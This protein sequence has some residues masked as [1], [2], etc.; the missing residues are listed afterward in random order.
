MV[1]ARHGGIEVGRLIQT[2]V[3]EAFGRGQAP[4]FGQEGAAG[5]H[6]GH[7]VRLSLGGHR[8][9]GLARLEQTQVPELGA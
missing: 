3:H 9:E 5:H 2:Q 6:A 4:D 7:E 1:E 8:V